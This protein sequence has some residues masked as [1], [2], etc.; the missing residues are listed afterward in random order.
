VQ[1]TRFGGPEVLDVV[2]LPDPVPSDGQQLFD[3]STAG[4][5]YADT[6]HCATGES[7]QRA[8]SDAPHAWW[9]IEEPSVAGMRHLAG[10]SCHRAARRGGS[11]TVTPPHDELI[12]RRLWET[13]MGSGDLDPTFGTGGVATTAFSE[14]GDPETLARALLV[15][16]D[17]RVVLAGR[18]DGDTRNDVGVVRWLPD[19]SLDSQF[20]ADGRVQTDLG[21]REGAESVVRDG[22]GRLVAA[23][24]T[25]KRG[26]DHR[27][28]CLLVR[29]LP[30]G[31]LDPDFAA[32]GV[33]V[34]ALGHED[35]SLHDVLVQPDGRYVVLGTAFGAPS[36]L[37][38]A[39]FWPS[40]LLD[41]GFG[42][43]GV[44]HLDL[45]SQPGVFRRLR[46]RIDGGFVA[47]GSTPPESGSGSTFVLVGCTPTGHLD[48]GFGEDGVATAWFGQP[49]E[50]ARDVRVLPDGRLLA[51]GVSYS[52]VSGESPG[53]FAV[54]RFLPTGL[55]DPSF[56]SGDGMVSTAFTAD[57]G[58]VAVDRD[59]D[60]RFVV[61]GTVTLGGETGLALARYLPDGQLDP[62]FGTGG[63][64]ESLLGSRSLSVTDTV[65]TPDGRVVIGGNAEFD[66]RDGA[67][68]L[69]ARF[70]G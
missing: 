14:P 17:G 15:D 53:Q 58:A 32:G 2:D 60:G 23:G 69:A 26:P 33:L 54:A 63:R 40:G 8:V 36:S 52:P 24:S 51:V 20:G 59:P 19:G 29:Y 44:G 11:G 22:A 28:R 47:A 46:R 57:A 48:P 67:F 61:A 50:L 70:L 42:A 43:G 62:T 18:A 66:D 64:V 68:F 37:F 5:N 39:R 7:R 55:L 38:L 49:Q 65:L 12:P 31:R 1:I 4:V 25:E 3:V 41:H 27:D 9:Y 6:H 56:G 10:G 45:G 30:D 21:G 34:D 35:S 13:R 16:P